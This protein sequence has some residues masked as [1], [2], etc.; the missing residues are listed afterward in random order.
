MRD[1]PPRDG[2]EVRIVEVD[3]PFTGIG[4]SSALDLEGL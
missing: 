2:R 3:G 4:V 1:S